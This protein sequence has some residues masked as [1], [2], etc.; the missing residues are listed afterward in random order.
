MSPEE[1]DRAI[2]ALPDREHEELHDAAIRHWSFR[3]QNLAI[4]ILLFGAMFALF[5][6]VR[7]LIQSCW[8]GSLVAGTVATLIWCGILVGSLKFV[9]SMQFSMWRVR[10]ATRRAFKIRGDAA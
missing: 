7:A 6:A 9:L 2:S 8:P 10:W 4:A 5:I 1:I 3:V